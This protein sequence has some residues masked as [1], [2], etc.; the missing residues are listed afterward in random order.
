MN[1]K[2]VQ[3]K[4]AEIREVEAIAAHM[5]RELGTDYA[6]QPSDTEP[7]DV[8]LKSPSGVHPDR[9]VQVVSIPRD[10]QIRADNKY[11]ESL[12]LLLERALRERGVSH[13]V[14]DV[15]VL[16]NAVTRAVPHEQI[17][18]L[19]DEISKIAAGMKSGDAY[20]IDYMQFLEF[21]PELTAYIGNAVLFCDDAHDGMTVDTPGVAAQLP[22]DG[23]WIHE[24]IQ[25][26]LKKYGGPQA[27]KN[28]TL[29]IAVEAL[30]DR[31][32]VD[33]FTAAN[34]AEALPFAEVWINSMEGVVC[35]KPQQDT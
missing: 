28:L 32:Q 21:D 4:A 2:E 31:Q 7:A 29:V 30:V 24:G 34:P 15:T 27:V 13:L 1:E 5:N 6:A 12:K 33:A 10:Y 19:A 11:L 16:A 22:D 17:A 9:P 20:S 8:I 25:L 23:K 3:K 35:L 26:K 14:V 18:N